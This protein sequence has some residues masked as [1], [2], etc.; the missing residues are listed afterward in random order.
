[1]GKESTYSDRDQSSANTVLNEKVLN[2]K[3]LFEIT[4]DLHDGVVV[5]ATLTLFCY[6]CLVAVVVGVS[7]LSFLLSS[8][9]C[10]LLLLLLLLLSLSMYPARYRY[11]ENHF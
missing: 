9:F 6:C 4:P 3:K 2:E 5:G 7:S 1:V 8:F 11:F 10:L